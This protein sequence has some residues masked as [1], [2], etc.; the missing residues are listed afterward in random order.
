MEDFIKSGRILME[1]AS[2]AE[3]AIGGYL[4]NNGSPKLTAPQKRRVLQ[5]RVEPLEIEPL[6]W[7][8]YR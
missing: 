4:L 7:R 6:V 1:S 5:F 2:A 3:I 8:R